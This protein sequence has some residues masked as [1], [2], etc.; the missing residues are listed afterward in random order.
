MP[1]GH[2]IRLNP[3]APHL[4][5]TADRFAGRH[6]RLCRRIYAGDP[7]WRDN[8]SAV[9]RLIANPRSAFARGADRWP[10][11]VSDG[12][13]EPVA[14]ALL[15]RAHR[16]PDTLQVG[17]LEFLSEPA[18]AMDLLLDQ[19]RSRA[20]ACG[21]TRVVV[22]CNGH[23]NNGL[24]LLA[25]PFGKPPSFG[26]A[27][28]PPYYTARLA[29]VA[30]RTDTLVSYV[31]VVEDFAGAMNPR[32]EQRAAR[33]F[34]VRPANFR[35]LHD[36]IALY[37][38]LNNQA[39]AG[40]PHYFERTVAEDLELYRAF[41]PLLRGENLLFVE[42]DGRPVGFLL[43]YPDFNEWVA[44][45]GAVGL[46]TVIRHRLLG[47]RPLR[48]KLAE[49]GICPGFRR[50][51]AILALIDDCFARVRGRYRWAE[52]GWI[53]EQNALS[54]ALNTR[55]GAVPDKSYQVFHLDPGAPAS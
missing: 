31:H 21:C 46:S 25:G 27:S 1:D 24:G 52:S 3:P 33:H 15:V 49:V 19:A 14:A 20:R 41:G 12:T 50:S 8:F 4:Q 42:H 23:V 2:G 43:W 32:L 53:H 5:V 38:A 51:G 10:V 36:E 6:A 40:H 18:A 9:L 7:A 29:G 44:P 47:H 28:H 17:F 37:T 30:T 35:H 45:G 39:F 34:R 22:G 11:V 55:W 26:S 13:G 16:Q 54:R 48:L